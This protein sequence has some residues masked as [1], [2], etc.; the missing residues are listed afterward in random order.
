MDA[1]AVTATF[2]YLVR[3]SVHIESKKVSKDTVHRLA[4]RPPP[5]PAAPAATPPNR[6]CSSVSRRPA[7]ASQQKQ[8]S[9]QFA[10][11]EFETQRT[12]SHPARLP[13]PPAAVAPPPLPRLAP[14]TRAE[15]LRCRGCSQES[16]RR[17]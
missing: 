11:T 4:V 7:A 13:A 10:T 12:T 1:T 6:S 9:G 16:R 3:P 17:F 2:R 14:P 5:P 8:Q 15:L